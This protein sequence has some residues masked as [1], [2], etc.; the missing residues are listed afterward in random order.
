MRLNLWIYWKWFL[1]FIHVCY[2]RVCVSRPAHLQ[3]SVY[4]YVTII[5][6]HYTYTIPNQTQQ[7]ERDQEAEVTMSSP[8]SSSEPTFNDLAA[9]LSKSYAER[10]RIGNA[11]PPPRKREE[12]LIQPWDTSG[13]WRPPPSENDVRDMVQFVKVKFNNYTTVGRGAHTISTSFQT[14]S[15]I[16]FRLNSWNFDEN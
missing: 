1:K 11:R 5:P 4:D 7:I 16:C 8:P 12:G 9:A 15:L 14:A 3:T 6:L 10:K 13:P 2:L